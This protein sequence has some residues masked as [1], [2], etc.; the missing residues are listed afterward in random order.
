MERLEG[1]LARP[2]PGLVEV[3][4]ARAGLRVLIASLA[5]GGAERIVLEWLAAEHARGRAIELA[6]L[7][8]RRNALA[9]P[10]G[11]AVRT[12]NRE[13]PEAFVKA[14][15]AGWRSDPAPVSTHLVADSLL[16]LL[17]DAGVRTVP[18]VHN[19]RE[20]WRNDP[21]SWTEAHVPLAVACAESVGRQL[22]EDGCR[23]PLVT[24]RHRPRV[25]TA[26]FDAQARGEIRAQLG[27]APGTFLV[28]AVGALKPQKDYPRA[29]EVMAELCGLRDAALVVLGGILDPT[30]L[31]ELDRVMDRAIA[32]G[33]AS[34]LRLPGF[35]P[36]IEPWLAACDALLNVS[37]YE[38]FSIA[39]QEA[40]AAGLPVVATDV[41]GQSEIYHP[42]LELVA[43]ETSPRAIAESLARLPVRKALAACPFV[44]A[45][46]VW[47]LATASR[48]P[49]EPRIETLF[50]TANLNAG[51][52]Q[53][54]LVNLARALSR[55]HPLAVAVCG[56]TTQ[57]AF[58]AEL[59][60]EGIDLFRPAPTADPFAVAESLLAHAHSGAA[61]NLCFWNADPR[62]KLLVAKFAPHRFRL[63]DVSPGAYAFAEMQAV[64][65]FAESVSSSRESYYG[66]LDVLVLKYR[67]DDHPACRRVEV[68]PNGV[69][70]R[71]SPRSTPGQPRFLVSGRIAPSK[72]LEAIVAAFARV[73]AVYPDAEMHVVGVAEERHREYAARLLREAAAL[74]IRFRGAR[75]DHAHLEEAFT[76]AVILGTHQGSPN[77]L[78]EAMAAAIPVI[79]NDSGGTRE[80]V[81]GGETGWLLAEDAA[82]DVLAEA[83]LEAIAQPARAA[84]MAARGLERV[85]A[86][87]TL[88]AMACRYLEL[89]AA[90]S[91]PRREKMPAW[92]SAS[93]P[94]APRPSLAAIS[95]AT[96]VR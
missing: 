13:E 9:V 10:P 71:A 93:A 30:G 89:L 23:V 54:S 32:L 80:L 49:T 55:R 92:N 26:A 41:G 20:G 66:R 85:R 37:R 6:V 68:V 59:G 8:A 51:G 4:D 25:G 70:A 27:L 50:V 63:I 78:L 5:P 72:R 86:D 33:V 67:T 84:Q 35:V 21:R 47:S 16:A 77:A 76:A 87:F 53:R 57:A 96:A 60:S 65:A 75:F 61:A 95:P 11:I 29:L 58:A 88:E 18:T 24:L 34:R 22:A 48:A 91:G 74:P 28:G 83:M 73:Q 19:S 44:R 94:A 82:A 56:E 15:A 7:H 42:A 12:R 90:E 36:A 40:L 43:A 1:L 31:G 52:A 39:V 45:P 17:W 69:A 81:A 2:I 79:A 3:R 46:R 14:L 38:G 62:V 64:D